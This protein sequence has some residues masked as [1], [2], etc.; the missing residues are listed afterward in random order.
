MVFFLSLSSSSESFPLLT[1]SISQPG[2]WDFPCLLHSDAASREGFSLVFGFAI[3]LVTEMKTSQGKS[4]CGGEDG[5][6]HK[7]NKTALSEFIPQPKSEPGIQWRMLEPARPQVGCQERRDSSLQVSPP[8]S[9]QT[10]HIF[11]Y[12]I[13]VAKMCFLTCVGARWS[14]RRDAGN[15]RSHLGGPKDG[16]GC[17]GG[18]V[19]W[20]LPGVSGGRG[21]CP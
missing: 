10:I 7:A 21:R 8:I 4:A 16:L 3:S 11:K 5:A 12:P 15:A 20:V 14:G 2:P 9:S 6:R 1:H 17:A 18:L 13:S 19:G